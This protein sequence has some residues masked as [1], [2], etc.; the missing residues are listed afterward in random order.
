M[1]DFSRFD[2]V[3]LSLASQSDGIEGMLRIVF[4]FLHRR[5]DFYVVKEARDLS[6]RMGFNDGEAERILLRTFKSFAFKP[7]SAAQQKT[8]R[9][10]KNKIAKRSSEAAKSKAPSPVAA[11]PQ[12]AAASHTAT[13]E[14]ELPGPTEHQSVPKM[15]GAAGALEERES[16]D[17]ATKPEEVRPSLK[18]NEDGKQIPVNNGGATDKYVWSQTLGEATMHVPLPEGMRARDIRVEILPSGLTV[19]KKADDDVILAGQWPRRIQ[20]DESVWTV[21]NGILTISLDKAD[22]AWW[23]SALVGDVEI[24]TTQVD[25]RTKIDDYDDETQGVIRKIMFDQKQKALG[26]PTSDELEKQEL[27]ERAKFAPGSPFLP[28]GPFAE[29]PE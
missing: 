4:D 9:K 8:V 26:L 18:V 7:L 2:D 3:F 1:A 10:K 11:S 14:D 29:K 17:P 27:F 16:K 15:D 25:S 12:E 20:G 24:D 22:R 6:A 28:G 13:V 21:D 19:R 23:S 5:T